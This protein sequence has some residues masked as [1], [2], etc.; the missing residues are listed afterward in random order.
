MNFTRCFV[1]ARGVFII[2]HHPILHVCAFI[3]PILAPRQ[4]DAGFL[5]AVQA[6]Y[7]EAYTFIPKLIFFNSLVYDD[8]YIHYQ[9]DFFR[10]IP[11]HH[12]PWTHICL[13]ILLARVPIIPMHVHTRT[14]LFIIPLL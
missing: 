4:Y 11:P 13:Y 1:S 12:A 7:Y 3:H 14:F 8:L 9:F 10:L 2:D 6:T 5:L